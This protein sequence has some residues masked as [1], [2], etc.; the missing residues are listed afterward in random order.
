M[1]GSYAAPVLIFGAISTGG[2]GLWPA[3]V[4]MVTALLFSYFFLV[5]RRFDPD[6]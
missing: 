6:L 4:Y 5:R 3:A 1:L 2:T